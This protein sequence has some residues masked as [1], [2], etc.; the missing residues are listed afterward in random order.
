M[1]YRLK[2]SFQKTHSI[3][4]VFLSLFT[5]ISVIE[6]GFPLAANGWQTIYRTFFANN[7]NFYIYSIGGSTMSGWPYGPKTN[8]AKMVAEA[9]DGK[10]KGKSIKIIQLAEPGSNLHFQYHKLKQ[11]LT[12]KPQNNA[13]IL[14]YAGINE[15]L[16]FTPLE[17]KLYPIWEKAQK[18]LILSYIFKLINTSHT[19]FFAKANNVYIN[20]LKAD[21]LNKYLYFLNQSLQLAENNN[22]PIIVSSLTCN[23]SDYNPL[24]F[25]KKDKDLL[26]DASSLMKAIFKAADPNTAVTK[27][28]ISILEAKFTDLINHNSID[29]KIK[30]NQFFP[31]FLQAKDTEKNNPEKANAL[32]KKITNEITDEM[33]QADFTNEMIFKS[34]SYRTGKNLEKTKNFS[35]ALKFYTKSQPHYWNAERPY[36][37]LNEIIKNF[38]STKNIPLSDTSLRMQD[39]ASNNL[40]GY[41]L[42]TDATHPNIKGYLI[43]AY[44]FAE[45]ITALTGQAPSYKKLSPEAISQRHNIT[46]DD[47]LKAYAISTFW[48]M[49]AEDFSNDENIYAVQQNLKK[50]K[51][52]LS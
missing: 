26:T 11:N 33:M 43:L 12:L 16:I 35:D 28:E 25:Y 30:T 31:M 21:S 4:L 3:L 10:I 14:L 20:Y 18:S 13:I 9:F 6:F 42:F 52:Y 37:H 8:P 49:Q 17:D 36:I 44:G 34:A 5:I 2:K 40:P 27:E 29:P 1:N 39:A 50:I 19:S 48:L 51:S 46:D 32:Y 22:I 41:D 38:A 45:Q 23:V 15:N 47:M 7:D 24:H